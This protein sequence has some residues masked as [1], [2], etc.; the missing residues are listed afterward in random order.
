M[1]A[2]HVF[3]SRKFNVAKYKVNTLIQK[4]RVALTR[5][6]NPRHHLCHFL[7]FNLPRIFNTVLF[8]NDFF[9]RCLRHKN[10]NAMVSSFSSILSSR[11]VRGRNFFNQK[12]H[13]TFLL[14]PF[15]QQQQ[16]SFFHFN[17]LKL[18]QFSSKLRK[19]MC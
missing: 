16:K 13:S 6:L 14:L 1:C 5:Q 8:I 2:P 9:Q 17:G 18:A 7:K 3:K 12:Q 11:P 4:T 19:K 10:K 15:Q